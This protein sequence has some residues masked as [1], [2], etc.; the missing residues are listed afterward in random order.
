MYSKEFLLYVLYLLTCCV[1][2]YTCVRHRHQLHKYLTCPAITWLPGAVVSLLN[3]HT[4]CRGRQ[5][6]EA[7]GGAITPVVANLWHWCQ[8]WHSEASLWAH[9]LSPRHRV[10]Q[11]WHL[12]AVSGSPSSALLL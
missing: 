6:Q 1:L 3:T 2:L 7:H 10:C 11:T 5:H 12:P 9:R 8:R 4:G